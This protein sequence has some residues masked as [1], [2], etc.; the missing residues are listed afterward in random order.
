MTIKTNET[1]LT[2]DIIY[3][4]PHLL[5]NPEA[6]DAGIYYLIYLLN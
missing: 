5:A 3:C 1:K 2:R 4:S 6:S